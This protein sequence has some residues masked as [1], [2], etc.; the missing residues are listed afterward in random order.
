MICDGG[1][2]SVTIAKKGEFTVTE[3]KKGAGIVNPSGLKLTYVK[4]KLKKHKATV[5]GVLVNGIGYGTIT[6]KRIGTWVVTVK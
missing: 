1:I 4:G 2:L 3:G 6:I 5:E